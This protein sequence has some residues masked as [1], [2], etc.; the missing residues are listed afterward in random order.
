MPTNLRVQSCSD[1]PDPTVYGAI[2]R[3]IAN[4]ALYRE[5]ER[6]LLY[7]RGII[8]GDYRHIFRHMLNIVP[9][10][11]PK[12]FKDLFAIWFEQ[13]FSL[14][15]VCLGLT[16][17]AFL[18]KMTLFTLL[19]G[20]RSYDLRFLEWEQETS[21][22][23]RLTLVHG[24]FVGAF[25]AVVSWL[26]TL[27]KNITTITHIVALGL[28]LT[29]IFIRIGVT[30]LAMS[31]YWLTFSLVTALGIQHANSLIKTFLIPTTGIA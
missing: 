28:C 4:S 18:S 29:S 13:T 5:P 21:S 17:L 8:Q 25:V 26:L 14:L 9:H 15:L 11:G 12:G 31:I 30:M 16:G 24:G 23:L 27:W 20:F 10:D 3:Y 1:L 6:F 19:V 22:F 2:L 7:V